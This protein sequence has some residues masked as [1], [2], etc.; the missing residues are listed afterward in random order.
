MK[1]FQD[2]IDL[3]DNIVFI[4]DEGDISSI[5]ANGFTEQLGFKNMYSL[6][7]GIQK[8]INENSKLI[9]K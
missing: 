1:T 5:L 3:D 7:G 6:E 2:A 4:S 8:I 9:K